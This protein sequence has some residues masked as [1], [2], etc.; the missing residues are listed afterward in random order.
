MTDTRTK[1]FLN[2]HAILGSLPML[3]ALDADASALLQAKNTDRTVGICVTNGP[4]G[5]F[6][7]QGGACR[8]TECMPSAPDTLDRRACD[9]LLSFPTPEKFNG[10]IDGTVTPIPKKGLTKAGFLTGPFTRLTDRLTAYLRPEKAALAD[11]K[12]FRIS[13]YLMFHVIAHAV[14][15]IGNEDAIG[16]LSA[17]YIP[18]GTL[19]LSAGS[20][21][22]FAICFKDHKLTLSADPAKEHITSEMR[23]ADLT[24][25]R[26]LFDGA[27]NAV[28]S[29]GDGIIQMR[30]M[31]PQVDN[32][33]RILDRVALYL[34]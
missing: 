4:A 26:A 30:G 14:C 17:S 8:Y 27:I 2:L 18:D 22:S 6:S 33:N 13:T 20:D 11:P 34:A 9:I 19:L 28:S 15:C 25:A 21:I 7:F 29:V 10:M 31:I 23:F 24:T 12:F 1:A 32:V 16:Q 3:C 5:M